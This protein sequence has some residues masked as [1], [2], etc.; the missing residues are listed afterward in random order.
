MI[1]AE[2]A[3]TS[4]SVAAKS[5]GVPIR[6]SGTLAACRFAPF[7]TRR[8]MRSVSTLAGATQLILTPRPATSFARL[9]ENM[10]MAASGAA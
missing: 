8:S 9:F 10:C 3:D 6:P 7:G 2:A 1:Q 4:N 5:S